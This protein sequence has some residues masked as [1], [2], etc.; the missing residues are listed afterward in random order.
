MF[1]DSRIRVKRRLRVRLRG[2]RDTVS[3]YIA[4]ELLPMGFHLLVSTHTTAHVLS[5]PPMIMG[6]FV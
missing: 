2:T 6:R 1:R 5:D 3:D 4:S